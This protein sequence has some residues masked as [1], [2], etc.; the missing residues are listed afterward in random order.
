MLCCWVSSFSDR[1]VPTLLKHSHVDP[2]H[3]KPNSCLLVENFTLADV[4][5]ESSVGIFIQKALFPPPFYD[6]PA[7]SAT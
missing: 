5:R 6:D 7:P 3:L 1:C 4:T 2:R